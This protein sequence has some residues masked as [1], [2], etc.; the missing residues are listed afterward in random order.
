MQ[1]NKGGER[2]AI[3]KP[4]Q[5]LIKF[6]SIYECEIDPGY[7]LSSVAALSTM[8]VSPSKLA[9]LLQP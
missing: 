5:I 1:E 8:Y 7:I 3:K 9:G 6:Q 4:P 2:A